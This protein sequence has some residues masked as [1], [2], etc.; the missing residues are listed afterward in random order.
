MSDPR[1]P[2]PR[3]LIPTAVLPPVICQ[4]H[5]SSG[6][7]CKKYAIVGG[8]VCAT[9]GG[10]APQVRA[11]ANRRLLALAPRA[12]QVLADLMEQAESEPVR[13]RAAIDL[14]DRVLGRAVTPI[15]V[16]TPD[17]EDAS[18]GPS[19]LDLAIARALEIRGLG[20]GPD[21]VDAE[22]LDD[23]ELDDQDDASSQP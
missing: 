17:A 7:P 6:R 18:E 3:E 12:V 2:D 16:T 22:V 11:A 23:E 14:L 21:I 15:D 19:S 20:P 1:S 9:H 4:A 10:S 5:T 13:A 8:F